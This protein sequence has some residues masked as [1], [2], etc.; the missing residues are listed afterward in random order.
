MSLHPQPAAAD[1]CRQVRKG[2]VA[3][4][5]DTNPVWEEEEWSFDIEPHDSTMSLRVFD[6]HV[7]SPALIG[8]CVHYLTDFKNCDVQTRVQH[9][10]PCSLSQ[11]TSAAASQRCCGC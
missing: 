9:A 7:L 4:G 8:Y 5:G 3:K 1:Q 6:D 2:A 11:S 10:P